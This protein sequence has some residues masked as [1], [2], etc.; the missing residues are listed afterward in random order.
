MAS[1]LDKRSFSV[2]HPAGDREQVVDSQTRTRAKAYTQYLRE[3]V[4]PPGD[5][6]LVKLVYAQTWTV[7]RQAPRIH[8]CFTP[9]DPILKC[10][11][12]VHLPEGFSIGLLV[13]AQ[14]LAPQADGWN[15]TY[16][17]P[18]LTA[19]RGIEYLISA[20]PTPTS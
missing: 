3:F 18:L 20:S 13:N 16:R 7:N 1:H 9:R 17:I 14:E 15:L 5:A 4:I 8:N 19:S 11:I 2:V 12:D 6:E 10:R